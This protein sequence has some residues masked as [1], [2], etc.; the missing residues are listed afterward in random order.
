MYLYEFAFLNYGSLLTYHWCW[1]MDMW[2][3]G[4]IV[5]TWSKEFHNIF[6]LSKNSWRKTQAGVIKLFYFELLC[7]PDQMFKNVCSW[8]KYVPKLIWLYSTT[9]CYAHLSS[10]SFEHLYTSIFW[11]MIKL[12]TVSSFCSLS[13]NAILIL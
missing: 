9:V 7:Q 2:G 8:S 11:W 13:S 6:W 10:S 5:L 1:T 3:W 4:L 12:I